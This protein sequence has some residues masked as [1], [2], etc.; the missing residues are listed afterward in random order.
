MIGQNVGQVQF[1][2][3]RLEGSKKA[4]ES[5]VLMMHDSELCAGRVRRFLSHTAPGGSGLRDGDLN[6][7]HI[8]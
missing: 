3:S 4:K 1:V 2:C 5:A 6:I 7:A 8:R